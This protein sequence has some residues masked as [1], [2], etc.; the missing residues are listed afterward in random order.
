[1]CILTIPIISDPLCITRYFWANYQHFQKKPVQAEFWFTKLF[2]EQAPLAAYEGYIQFLFATKKFSLIYSMKELILTNFASNVPLLLTLTDVLTLYKEETILNDTLLQVHQKHPD[3]PNLTL[4]VVS[5]LLEQKDFDGAISR[6]DAL[7]NKTSRGPSIFLFYF[8]KAQIYLQVNRVEDAI[9][10]TK[11]STDL[12]P[13]FDKTW[14][15]LGI[16][17]EQ[18]G[19]IT[20]AIHAY[21]QYDSCCEKPSPLF[22]QRSLL[23][24][25]QRN[26][27]KETMKS[28]TTRCNCKDLIHTYIT[29][30]EYGDAMRHINVFLEHEPENREIK[31]LKVTTLVHQKQHKTAC[32]TLQTYIQSDVEQRMQWI[33]LSQ[34]LALTEK[35]MVPHVDIILQK[36]PPKPIMKELAEGNK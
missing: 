10:A 15:V 32:D 6:I 3:N 7:L 30:K 36:Y 24:E 23:L 13:Y 1:M 22:T 4:R 27:L 5:I 14:L 9:F 25:L 34:Q 2:E 28:D 17:Y 21:R 16:L 35:D 33:E 12:F 8:M 20:D 19:N 11:K 26:Q 29:K 18:L 31:K